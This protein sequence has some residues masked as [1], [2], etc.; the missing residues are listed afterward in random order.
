VVATDGSGAS[1][2]RVRTAL[3]TSFPLAGPPVGVDQITPQ[4]ARWITELEDLT[5]AVIA[6][7]LII[8]ACGLAVNVTAGMGDRK[9]PFSL[10]RLVGVPMRLLRRAVLLEAVVPLLLTALV[11]IAAGLVASELYLRSE[12]S[13]TLRPPGLSY[14]VVVLI[15]LAASLGIVGLSLPVIGRIAGPEVARNG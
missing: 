11:S 9:R 8:A 15:G 6:V 4:N 14:Y 2:E 5:D 13:L 3:E 10:L 7:S 1:I 12:L